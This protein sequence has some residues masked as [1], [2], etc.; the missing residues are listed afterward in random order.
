M[1]QITRTTSKVATALAAT[2]LL[3]PGLNAATI[4]D[5]NDGTAG[6]DVGTFYNS[7]GATF[8]NAEWSSLSAGF[9]P[10]PE[11]SGLRVVGD[12][13][14]LQPKAGNP[15][16]IIFSTPIAS[17][18]LIANNVNANGAR[19]D[20]YDSASGG[21]LLDFEQVVGPSGATNSNFTLGGT[22]SGI[23]RA[24]F[25]Q[26]FSV[27]S[28]GVLIDNLTFTPIPEPSSFLLFSLGGLAISTSRTRRN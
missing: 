14:N 4:I 5:F 1:K 25:Y 15:I 23:L 10:A 12:G 6:S 3:A 8:L 24:E 26:P 18:S 21:A 11:S 16:V 22:G 9:T 19:L 28:E 13:A 27:E 2:I 17:V 20:L 7:F